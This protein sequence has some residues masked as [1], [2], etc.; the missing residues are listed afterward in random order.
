MPNL[1]EELSMAKERRPNQFGMAVLVWCS[2]SI[3]CEVAKFELLSNLTLIGLTHGVQSESDVWHVKS[4][5]SE[6]GLRQNANAKG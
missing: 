5:V 3:I 6:P 1:T 2:K 4:T